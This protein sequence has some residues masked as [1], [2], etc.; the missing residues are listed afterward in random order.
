MPWDVFISHAT[1]DKEAVAAPLAMAL[2]AAGISVWYDEFE[3]RVGDGLRQSIEEGLGKSRFGIVILSPAFFQKR[4]PQ[5]ELDG[6][7]QQELAG[8]SRILP[9]WHQV[10]A[11]EV[12]I[13]S[14]IL[15]NR[16]AVNWAEGLPKVVSRILGVITEQ[17][18]LRPEEQPP[19]VAEPSVADPASLV[20]L[21]TN[22]GYLLVPSRLVTWGADVSMELCP[23]SPRESAF[24][25]DLVTRNAPFGIAAANAAI[26]GRIT[27]SAAVLE[28]GKE[29]WKLTLTEEATDYGT[30]MEA[31][32]E[33][34]SADEIA[35]LRARRI[36]LDERL[37]SSGKR[38]G[39][40][41]LLEMFVAGMNTPLKVPHSP[42]PGIYKEWKDDPATFLPLARLT[43]ITWLRLS[44]TVEHVLHLDMSLADGRLAVEFEGQRKRKYV[45]A[46]PY[47]IKVSGVCPLS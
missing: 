18:S 45:N 39:A 44:G 42:L 4:W 46:G 17:P 7:L 16:F 22:E 11:D 43:A 8:E 41:D 6:L 32:V 24:L 40:D 23:A 19:V 25:R 2:K 1:E 33:G 37:G 36:L 3:L 10:S 47:V 31:S 5:T 9:V 28:Q 13:F 35:E 26:L 38:F 12:R 20:L 34:R 27:Q 15:S 14:P 30:T 29:I 21:M